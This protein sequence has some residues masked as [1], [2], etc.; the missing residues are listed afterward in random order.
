MTEINSWDTW[1]PVFATNIAFLFCDHCCILGNRKRLLHTQTKI[2]SNCLFIKSQRNTGCFSEKPRQWWF[3]T[4]SH[5][6]FLG[7]WKKQSYCPIPRSTCSLSSNCHFRSCPEKMCQDRQN[8]NSLN[9]HQSILLHTTT[10]VNMAL[11]E[12]LVIN[13]S[14]LRDHSHNKILLK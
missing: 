11:L 12:S 4:C 10:L 2:C 13:K 9:N 1:K 5:S 8:T 3:T 7:F 6:S 14:G